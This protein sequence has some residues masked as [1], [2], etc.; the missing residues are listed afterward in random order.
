MAIAAFDIGG[1]SVKYGKWNGEALSEKGHFPTPKTWAEMQTAIQ[2]AFQV[3]AGQGAVRAAAFS[4]PGAVD[5]DKGEIR[6]FSAIPYI[7]HFPIKAELEQ[8]LGVPVSIENDANCAALAEVWLGAASQVDHCLFV[9]VGTG[10]GGAVI[11]DRQLV[12]GGEL[13]GGEFGFMLLD[14]QHTLSQLG[15]PVQAGKRYAKATGEQINGVELFQR[16][17]AGDIAAQR[18]ID[19]MLNALAQG[20]HNLLVSFNPELVVLGGA[21]SMREDLIPQLTARVEAMLQ[22]TKAS[23]IQVKLVSCRFRNDANLIGAVAA[24]ER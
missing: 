10:V 24:L 4:F 12:K 17:E 20:I 2:Q 9:V 22:H 5:S 13:F 15:S 7:H 6:G 16:A 8:A 18:E 1:T 19:R 3:M 11:M 14:G 23:D 21:I